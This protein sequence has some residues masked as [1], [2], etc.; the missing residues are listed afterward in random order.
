MYVQH[1]YIVYLQRR[2]AV[3]RY[4]SDTGPRPPKTQTADDAAAVQRSWIIEQRQRQRRE[5]ARTIG[6]S[7]ISVAVNFLPCSNFNVIVMS[8]TKKT[9]SAVPTGR[10]EDEGASCYTES[11]I[12][13]NGTARISSLPIGATLVLSPDSKYV[14]ATPP[15]NGDDIKWRV[16]EDGEGNR[17]YRCMHEFKDI[18][19]N[20]TGKY[21]AHPAILQ[22]STTNISSLIS[23]SKT[24]WKKVK[25]KED[26]NT[27]K[28]KLAKGQ[29]TLS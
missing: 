10:L 22:S 6:Q 3:V 23:H 27:K 18:K 16:E 7:C 20:P 21:C 9:P 19:D 13:F 14:G 28:A 8:R 29:K 5:T 4:W 17:L 15:Y 2:S 11:N 1:T 25:V 26:D 24:H 12:T